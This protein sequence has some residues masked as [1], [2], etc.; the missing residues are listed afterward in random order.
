MNQ[1]QGELPE[2]ISHLQNLE[3]LLL[4]SNNLS[5]KLPNG[6]RGNSPLTFVAF[7]NNMFSGE[8]PPALCNGFS[9]QYLL[10]SYNNFTGPLP[11][12]LRNCSGLVRVTFVQNQLTGD[13]STAFG[14]HPD[15]VYVDLS[16]NQFSG[17]L[18]PKWGQYASLTALYISGNKISG[19]IPAELGKL[20]QL[21][22]LS[23][24]SNELTGKI[25]TKLG[26]LRKLNHLNSSNN[27]LMGVIPQSVGNLH[28]LQELDLS[29]NALS[30]SLPKEL[31]NCIN[32]IQ[33]NLSNNGLSGAIPS[34]MA[35]L[36]DLQSFLD[37]SRN[38][39]TGP[40]PQNL[41]KLIKLENLNLSHNNLS[42][43]IPK[44]LADMLSL[45][46]IDLSFK[47]LMG[48]VPT[49][50][51]FQKTPAEAFTGNPGLCGVVKGLPTCSSG[52]ASGNSNKLKKILIAVIVPSFSIL[53][54]VAMT[55][56]ILILRR[57][58]KEADIEDREANKDLTSNSLIWGKEGKFTF[59]DIMEATENFNDKYCIGEGGSG[60]VFKAAQSTGY[61]LAVKRLKVSDS[62]D[63]PATNRR[64]FENEIRTLAGIRHRN[65][66]K[67]HGFCSK[68][69]YMYLVY[70]YVERGC[71]R[72]VLNGEEGREKL[73]WAARLKIIQG[74]AHAVAYLHHDCVPAIVHRDISLS[75][76]LLESDFV[77]RLSDFGTARLLTANSSNWT[78]IAGS[79]GY[80]VPCKLPSHSLLLLLR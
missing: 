57:K 19:E 34:E 56:G 50:K 39:L 68:N 76:I 24:S 59:G 18:S 29:A 6:L 45:Q 22:E 78:T 5:E 20:I 41:D 71:L 61:I 9:L 73:D 55:F 70:E 64:R 33:L 63:I 4:F 42:G 53:L 77:P 69:G 1:L 67:L 51:V 75:N 27:H 49:G 31:G 26:D 11:G 32:L 21:Q 2:N 48:P 13:I 17:V 10:M 74:V 62:S 44:T 36:I 46:N 37:L 15:L 16:E 7:S 3:S 79:Y 28:E 72:N 40:I 80:M 52:L 25:P 47:E 43:R 66:I 58:L 14:V 54:L 65:I 30:G 8:L 38:S 12:C 35:S 60:S 23:L